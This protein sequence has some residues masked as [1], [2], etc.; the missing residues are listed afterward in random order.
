VVAYG[1]G[2][3]GIGDIGISYV[4]TWKRLAIFND[5]LSASY[6]VAYGEGVYGIGDI[7]TSAAAVATIMLILIVISA[8]SV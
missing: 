2:V 8:V 6:V 5:V 1:E 3:Y 7:G 4:M